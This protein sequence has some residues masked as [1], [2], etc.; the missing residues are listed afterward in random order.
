MGGRYRVLG[1][2]PPAQGRGGGA[3]LGPRRSAGV[4]R[5]LPPLARLGRQVWGAEARS[6]D[7]GSVR[8]GAA[9]RPP[10]ARAAATKRVF[11]SN[12]AVGASAGGR[13]G[14]AVCSPQGRRARQGRGAIGALG[15]ITCAAPAR[16]PS[17]VG[18]RVVGA[19]QLG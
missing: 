6:E 8:V 5:Q 14:K 16:A 11:I 17:I 1:C 7:P 3:A 13:G 12:L 2:T 18:E 10:I 15:G 19:S 4:C 9:V